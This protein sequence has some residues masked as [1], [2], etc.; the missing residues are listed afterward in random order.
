M[1][2]LN[3]VVIFLAS[4]SLAL[5]KIKSASVYQFAYWINTNSELK[6]TLHKSSFNDTPDSSDLIAANLINLISK[7][8]F[9]LTYKKGNP[10]QAPIT[11]QGACQRVTLEKLISEAKRYN[12]LDKPT[13]YFLNQKFR[14][15]TWSDKGEFVSSKNEENLEGFY[16]SLVRYQVGA[17]TRSLNRFKKLKKIYPKFSELDLFSID[18]FHLY[19]LSLT[20]PPMK[21]AHI[22]KLN[23]HET[24][25]LNLEQTKPGSSVAVFSPVSQLSK[26]MLQY[27]QDLKNPAAYVTPYEPAMQLI[28]QTIDER[29]NLLSTMENE[30]N[31]LHQMLVSSGPLETLP[32]DQSKALKI[33]IKNLS[34]KMQSPK[35]QQEQLTASSVEAE[36]SDL[37]ESKLIATVNEAL[38]SLQDLNT[39]MVDAVDS[40][41]DEALQ[42]LDL[43]GTIDTIENV[44]NQ[45]GKFN[46]TN[47]SS[48]YSLTPSEADRFYFNN[49]NNQI[50]ASAQKIRS[51]GVDAT[52]GNSLAVA[53]LWGDLS[54]DEVTFL[55]KQPGVTY[56]EKK[57][58]VSTLN[59]LLDIVIPPLTILDPTKISPI[60]LSVTKELMNQAKKKQPESDTRIKI[61]RG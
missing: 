49:M 8:S 14:S 54:S 7:Q 50:K 18:R 17:M 59:F 40:N 58:L 22:G 57:F 13:F 1:K 43:S 26:P 34:D 39:T 4:S 23:I 51:Y 37:D 24:I 42:N 35:L 45:I 27:F 36:S 3:L 33:R 48:I 30:L 16:Q 20:Q 31:S 6:T 10:C 5:A 55:I 29:R 25:L 21:S 32:E 9:Y 28:S 46:K 15:L 61:N 11:S 47:T 60:L 2:F 38:V 53:Y 41:D 19:L 52:I 12:L 56:P 44:V